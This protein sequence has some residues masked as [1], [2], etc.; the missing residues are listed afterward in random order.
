MLHLTKNKLIGLIVTIL[1]TCSSLIGVLVYLENCQ[2]CS[3]NNPNP[4]DSGSVWDEISFTLVNNSITSIRNFNGKNLLI[5]FSSS[6]CSDCTQ[7]I[8]VIQ[9]FCESSHFNDSLVVLT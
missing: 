6:H 4:P 3:F 2:D 5:E 9:Q 1:I 7:Q 8:P